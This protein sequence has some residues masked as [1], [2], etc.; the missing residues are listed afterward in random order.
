MKTQN[1]RWI[2]VHGY[3]KNMVRNLISTVSYAGM[4]LYKPIEDVS[5]IK[6]TSLREIYKCFQTSYTK[7]YNKHDDRKE[8]IKEVEDF[9]KIGFTIANHDWVYQQLAIEL[10]NTIGKSYVKNVLGMHNP[11]EINPMR[12]KIEVNESG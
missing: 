10:Y 2:F 1:E 4:S 6:S 8:V 9:M 5:E 12:L 11:I 3:L 7:W